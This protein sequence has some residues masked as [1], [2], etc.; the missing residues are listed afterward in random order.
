[1]VY[2]GSWGARKPWEKW[3][4]NLDAVLL[5]CR[6]ATGKVA[7]QSRY[8]FVGE[9]WL[10]NLDAVLLGCSLISSNIWPFSSQ[11]SAHFAATLP[12]LA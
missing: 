1:M 4:S 2:G 5:G 11:G 7:L 10:S 12:D 6:E 9:K 8:C 3:L